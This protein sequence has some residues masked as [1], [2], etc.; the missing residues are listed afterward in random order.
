M[1]DF[2]E[3]LRQKSPSAKRW[4]SLGTSA[5]VTL[6][7]FLVWASVLRFGQKP[8]D[9]T[10]SVADS[11]E[12]DTQPFSAFWGVVSN[13]WSDFM[14][15]VNKTKDEI[16]QAKNSISDIASSTEMMDAAGTASNEVATFKDLGAIPP[17]G[18]QIEQEPQDEA[19][20]II[21]Q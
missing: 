12:V 11:S 8:E 2:I 13:G 1:L 16:N 19:F 17:A 14:D 10:A 4:I 3:K 5:A 21:T 6:L 20:V 7:I 18:T 9:L 15:T